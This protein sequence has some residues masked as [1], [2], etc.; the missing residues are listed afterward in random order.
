[1]R[2]RGEK[3]AVLR[4]GEIRKKG[5]ESR[6]EK[7]RKSQ[8]K[9]KEEDRNNRG[10]T[11]AEREREKARA[12]KTEEKRHSNVRLIRRCDDRKPKRSHKQR[13]ADKVVTKEV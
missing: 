3:A 9:R 5:W 1:M 2:K 11:I 10:M 13:K 7:E 4:S 8:K 6:E 12:T